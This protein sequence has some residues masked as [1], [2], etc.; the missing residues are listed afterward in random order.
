MF[1]KCPG[2]RDFLRPEIILRTCPVCGDSVEFFSDETEADCPS[3]GRKLHR[4]AK[5]SCVS[6]C[7]YASKCIED[8]VE[9]KLITPSRA[10]ELRKIAE[11]T[12][13]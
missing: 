10:E 11:K 2:V 6:W 13:K 3:C 4:E 8:L 1:K 12:P 7:T 5:P 9:R